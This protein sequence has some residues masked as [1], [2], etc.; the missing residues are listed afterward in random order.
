M[1][2]GKEIL[3]G[4]GEEEIADKL[5]DYFAALIDPLGADLEPPHRRIL[6]PVRFL[7]YLGLGI[8]RVA[9]EK[10]EVS[11]ESCQRPE[12]RVP[13][14]DVP[15]MQSTAQVPA[16]QES[17]GNV[18]TGGRGGDELPFLPARPLLNQVPV[19]G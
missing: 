2:P 1:T 17:H 15:A 4:T 5:G 10:E 19:P 8:D 7:E 18:L 9:H 16:P 14:G 11:R 12:D 6:R 13:I 3:P